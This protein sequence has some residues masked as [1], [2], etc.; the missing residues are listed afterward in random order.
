MILIILLSSLFLLSLAS[1]DDGFKLADD[2]LNCID[3]DECQDPAVCPDL[4]K[5]RVQFSIFVSA[6][7]L[8]KSDPYLS[9]YEAY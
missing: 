2:N 3:I 8:L 7:V 1:C 9:V 4:S 5:G 6:K